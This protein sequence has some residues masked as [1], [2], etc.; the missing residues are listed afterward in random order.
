MRYLAVLL[1]L[2]GLACIGDTQVAPS[3]FEQ[4]FNEYGQAMYALGYNHGIFDADCRQLKKLDL[5]AFK[6][7]CKGYPTKRNYPEP[8]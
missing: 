2:V 8:K 5:G 1:V 3:D 4:K 6:K 7:V